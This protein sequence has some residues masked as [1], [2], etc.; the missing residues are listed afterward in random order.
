MPATII[1]AADQLQK[2][3][4]IHF[5][6]GTRELLRIFQQEK[7]QH[8]QSENARALSDKPVPVRSA[9]A[10]PVAV[11]VLHVACCARPPG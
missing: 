3:V 6:R 2:R 4:F 8:P 7:R 10:N 5:S 11:I 9:I 1:K